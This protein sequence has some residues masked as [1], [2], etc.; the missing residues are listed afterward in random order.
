MISDEEVRRLYQHSSLVLARHGD[1]DKQLYAQFWRG[2]GPHNWENQHPGGCE[3]HLSVFGQF[4]VIPRYCFDCYKVLIK[5]RTVMELFKLMM[6]LAKLELP[7]DNTRKC[8]VEIREQ[9]SGTY[10]GNVYCRGG[11]RGQ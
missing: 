1:E 9:V 10:E 11:R 3:R 7:N 6:V 8:I 4:N 5:P 2:M